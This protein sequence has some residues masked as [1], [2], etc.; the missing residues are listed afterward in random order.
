MPRDTFDGTIAAQKLLST[1]WRTKE[2]SFSKSATF[3]LNHHVEVL[4]GGDSERIRK[5]RH[6][7][8]STYG[9]GKEHTRGEWQ[10][11]GRELVRLGLLRQADGEFPTIEMTEEG[12][13]FLKE[14]GKI[15]LT[16]PPPRSTAKPDEGARRRKRTG[17]IPC[18]ETLFETLR[19]LRREIADSR[20]VPAYVIFGDV[21]LRELAR[22]YPVE[23]REFANVSGVGARKL[24]E[25]G[26][27]FMDAIV[28]HL[29]ENPKQA[30]LD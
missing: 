22:D 21:T 15:T 18:D 10:A 11:I 8:L 4:T 12:V 16:R 23:E 19:K 20:N 9:I 6:E 1:V 27:Q 17:D 25:F 30:F 7:Q 13:R 2:A 14:R 5:W 29:R 3:G 24:E 26:A 28:K